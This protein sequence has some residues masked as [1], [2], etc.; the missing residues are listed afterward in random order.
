MYFPVQLY[1]LNM[2]FIIYCYTGMRDAAE[3]YNKIV[4]ESGYT[5]CRLIIPQRVTCMYV[6]PVST[7]IL[8]DTYSNILYTRYFN[9][10]LKIKE[11]LVLMKRMAMAAAQK[12]CVSL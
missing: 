12:C 11:C 9:I 6:S 8:I 7:A 10:E 3:Y 2:Y 4:C 5:I 1:G